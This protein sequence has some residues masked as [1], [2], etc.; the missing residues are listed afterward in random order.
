MFKFSNYGGSNQATRTTM[1]AHLLI[2]FEHP[3]IISRCLLLTSLKRFVPKQKSEQVFWCP[4]E[5]SKWSTLTGSRLEEPQEQQKQQKSQRNTNGHADQWP[6]ESVALC[7]R[8]NGIVHLPE[9]NGPARVVSGGPFSGQVYINFNPLFIFHL[10]A[11]S[12]I[13]SLQSAVKLRLQIA[14]GI[15]VAVVPEDGVAAR[16]ARVCCIHVCCILGKA[17]FNMVWNKYLFQSMLGQVL[18]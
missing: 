10:P 16:F 8:E 1:S 7:S 4:N 11:W 5:P 3:K 17:W 15:A 9:T 2:Q 12:Q 13:R 14:T 18:L 6:A